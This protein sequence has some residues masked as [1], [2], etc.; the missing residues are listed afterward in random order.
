MN[1]VCVPT[2]VNEYI[3]STYILQ[4]TY[5]VPDIMLGL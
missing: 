5:Y 1:H 2:C 3:N 4:T